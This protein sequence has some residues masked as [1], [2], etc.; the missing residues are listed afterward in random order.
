M[1]PIRSEWHISIDLLVHVIC[2]C[3]FKGNSVIVFKW[4]SVVH[5]VVCEV[6]IVLQSKYIK[7]FRDAATG[8]NLSLTTDHMCLSC[9]LDFDCIQ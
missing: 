2:V 3:F 7:L 6:A 4:L 9:F 5:M 1:D 8:P